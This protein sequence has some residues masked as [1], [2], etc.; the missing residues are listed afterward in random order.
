MPQ[1]YGTFSVNT[2]SG[3]EL[4][5][6]MQA[7]WRIVQVLE[8]SICRRTTRAKTYCDIVTLRFLMCYSLHLTSSQPVKNEDLL[9]GTIP[10][11]PG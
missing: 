10:G 5:R 1:R 7:I 4:P 2:G 11:F 6:T 3:E 8:Q 9:K